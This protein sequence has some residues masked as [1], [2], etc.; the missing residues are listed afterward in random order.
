MDKNIYKNITDMKK[1]LEL[2]N[3]FTFHHYHKNYGI[4][5]FYIFS[6][7]FLFFLNF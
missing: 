7:V 5:L 4:F 3:I 2:T 1:A 6:I